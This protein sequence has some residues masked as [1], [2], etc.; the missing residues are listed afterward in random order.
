MIEAFIIPN[1]N[2]RFRYHKTPNPSHHIN[3]SEIRT[4]VDAR[5]RQCRP[6]KAKPTLNPCGITV[7]DILV[8]HVSAGITSCNFAP[9]KPSPK[10]MLWLLL[11]G[12]VAPRAGIST[13]RAGTL[14]GITILVAVRGGVALAGGSSRG[15]HGTYTLENALDVLDG[16]LSLSAVGFELAFLLLEG[17][18]LFFASFEG[19]DVSQGY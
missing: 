16:G 8:P 10:P 9:N 1:H 6:G 14:A 4:Y 18:D 5:E 11:G 7:E 13:D 2:T 3:I 15:G 12:S 19:V 17:S